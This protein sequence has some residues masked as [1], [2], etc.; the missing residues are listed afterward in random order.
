[1][2]APRPRQSR[3]LLLTLAFGVVVFLRMAAAFAPWD[4]V[5]YGV[6]HH[7]EYLTEGFLS[8]HTYLSVDPPQDLLELKDPYKPGQ[9]VSRSLLD[10]SLYK[11]R[12]YI[13]Y[14]PTPAVLLMAPWRLATGLMIPQRVAV[15]LFGAA[16]LAALALLLRSVRARLYPG[17]SDAALAWAFFFAANASWLPV[18]IRRPLFW[19]LPIV[20]AVAC[21]WWALYFLWKYHDSG[22]SRRWA[23]ATGLALGFMVGS[24]VTYVFAS[25]LI[26]V[27]LAP[28][29]AGGRGRWASF[30]TASGIVGLMGAALLEYNHIRF[31]R[32]LEFGQSY[33]IWG[34]EYRNLKFFDPSYLWFNARTYLLAVG[35]PSPYF[36]FIR[37]YLPVDGPPGY[38]GMDE[39]YGAAAAVPV[40]V[41]GVAIVW[42]ALRSRGD[43]ASSGLRFLV[44]AGAATSAC[45]ALVLFFWGGACSRYVAELWSGWTVA[46]ALGL[47][48]VY[49]APGRPR[50][51]LKGLLAAA[52]A[53]TVVFVWLASIDSDGIMRLTRPVL[54][55]SLAHTL[56]YPSLW[57]AK[58]RGIGFGPVDVEVRV[59]PNTRVGS[60]AL[61]S[62]GRRDRSNELRLVR[63]ESG[64]AHLELVEEGSRVVAASDPLPA[65]GGLLRAHVEAPWL[66]PPQA[67]PYWDRIPDPGAR[68]RILTHFSLTVAGQPPRSAQAPSS[69]PEELEPAVLRQGDPG[70]AVGWVESLR[71]SAP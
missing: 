46:T 21:L 28:W 37:P 19:E 15:A 5:V 49:A 45:A 2:D 41:A 52:S 1:V 66:Y 42:H 29:R 61:L 43:P 3:I 38:M 51:L 53:W 18:V 20:A 67:H 40:Q 70:S 24:R 59:A 54:Y 36:P 35:K 30:W 8:G 10:A 25:G 50:P 26:L 55:D 65:G 11:G 14:G 47:L 9:K 6:G 39:V 44:A 71:R 16:G 27:C 48:Y 12:Y 33:Q 62:S 56:N 34:D 22:G 64:L 32:W 60:V 68:H 17:A 57:W 63:D 69:E 58:A 4:G 13:Y 7:Y 23:V 31:G